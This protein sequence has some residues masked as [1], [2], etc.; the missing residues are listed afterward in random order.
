MPRKRRKV[1]GTIR[2]KIYR[3]REEMTVNNIIVRDV[4]IFD[5]SVRLR[6]LF[7][8]FLTAAAATRRVR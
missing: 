6:L 8:V 1:K 3:Q 4:A 2:R 5:K 7:I